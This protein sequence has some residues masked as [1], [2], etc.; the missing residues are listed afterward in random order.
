MKI[1]INP[2]YIHLKE[3]IESIPLIFD[4]KGNSIYK[5]RN[6]IKT[7]ETNGITVNVKSYQKPIYINR[8]A[9]T[10]FRKT[11][12]E[13]AYEYAFE[14]IKREINTPTPIAYI[15]MKKGGLLSRSFFISLHTPMDGN[16]RLFGDTEPSISGRENLV[17]AFAKFSAEVHSKGVLH[18]D[19]SPGN[20]LY[21]KKGENY[22]F[23]LIDINRMKFQ[24]VSM[25][26]GCANFARMM[27]NIEFFERIAKNYASFRGFDPE[28]CRTLM[29][30][31]RQIDRKNR[32]KKNRMKKKFN[33]ISIN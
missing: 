6:E 14:L 2:A 11:K 13:R 15:E 24:D 12:A 9:Y 20:I 31:Y 8:I 25:E 21:E 4:R 18:K 3:F 17:D 22:N 5:A 29:L 1:I 16:L 7:F 26:E 19:Y 27:G 33:A 28:Q 30:K 32:E 23:S 10:F